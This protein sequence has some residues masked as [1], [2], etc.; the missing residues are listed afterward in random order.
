MVH[1]RL[2]LELVA[3]PILMDPVIEEVAGR[4]VVL[5]DLT[6]DSSGMTPVRVELEMADGTVRVREVHDCPGSPTRPLDW[7]TITNKAAGCA[8]AAGRP[9]SDVVRLRAWVDGLAS[10]TPLAA[11]AGTLIDA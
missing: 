3:G 11:L 8:R 10:V 2:D 7:D 4:V 1:R 9:D 5:Q 6:E